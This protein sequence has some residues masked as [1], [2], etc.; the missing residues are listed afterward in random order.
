MRKNLTAVV[1]VLTLTSAGCGSKA[2]PAE[3][4][5]A[6]TTTRGRVRVSSFG[7]F[8]DAVTYKAPCFDFGEAGN[9]DKKGDLVKGVEVVAR[10][11]DGKFLARTKLG[12]G[13]PTDVDTCVFP[14][15]LTLTEGEKHYVITVGQR[16]EAAF[17][18][19]QVK[20]GKV[21]LEM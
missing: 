2:K 18:W 1:V 3:T 5:P 12:A 6:E 13:K 7:A 16:P 21:N 9:A 14:F 11:D 8:S 20:A 10:N 19:S 17:T 4:K 15:T